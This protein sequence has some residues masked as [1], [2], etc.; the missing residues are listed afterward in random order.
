MIIGIPKEVKAQEHRVALL[1][2]GVS[3]LCGAG[4]LVIVQSM[5]GQAVGYPDEAYINA[6]ASI[7]P[8]A[9]EVYAQADLIVKVKEPQPQ[10]YALLRPEQTL[11]CYLHLAAAPELAAVLLEKNITAIAY[12]TVT[13][14]HGLLPLLIP[15]SEIAG[16]LATQVGANA[17]QMHLGGKGILLGGVPGV[18]PAKVVVIGAG[19][20]GVEAARIAIGMGADVTIIDINAPRLRELDKRFGTR[21][22]TVFSTMAAIYEA[23]I[24]ADLLIGSVLVPG[25]NAPKLITREM[26]KAMSDGSVLVDVAIDQG[27]CAETSIATSHDKPTYVVDGVI[28]YCVANIPSACAVTATKALTNVTLASILALANEGVDQAC[29]N[30]P[31][32]ANGLNIHKG[33]VVH[34]A[35][36]KALQFTEQGAAN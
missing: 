3:A 21:I 28:H 4:H 14:R 8:Q 22:K 32:L 33:K 18:L 7:V 36:Q 1:P 6:G 13:D 17:L 12:E 15:M 30:N 29:K 5:A 2:S 31:G 25:E 24:D 34:P 35:V 16:R 27:G 9:S 26:I 20:V 19:I 23:V 10:E 11:F